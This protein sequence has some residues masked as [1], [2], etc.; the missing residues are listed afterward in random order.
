M[1]R[2]SSL[3]NRENTEQEREHTYFDRS[4]EPDADVVVEQMI[5]FLRGDAEYPAEKIKEN[6]VR[7]VWKITL[8]RHGAFLVKHYRY[9]KRYD[10][11]RYRFV[12][13]KAQKEAENLTELAR[14][15]VPVPR[16]VA[17]KRLDGRE[18]LFVG[19]FLENARPWPADP[20]RALLE[21]L[22]RAVRRLHD[23]KFYHRDLHPGNVLLNDESICLIDFHRGYFLPYL[24]R[25]WEI[26]ML[27]MLM[28]GFCATNDDERVNCFVNA[29][30]GEDAPA[31]QAKVRQAAG[32]LIARQLRSRSRRCV[33]NSTRFAVEKRG[34]FTVFRRRAFSRDFIMSLLEADG[35][36][37]GRNHRGEVA[38][39]THEGVDV[40]R[41]RVRYS[42]VR[43]YA[44]RFFPARLY[45]AWRAGNG[46][47]VR[48]VDVAEPLAYVR[49]IR[50]GSLREE[51][52]ITS[53]LKG[54]LPLGR[55][56][57][58]LYGRGQNAGRAKRNAFLKSLAVFIAKLHGTGFRQ[59]DLAPKNIFVREDRDSW[60]YRLIDLDNVKMRGLN[61]RRILR[62][63]VQ[64]GNTEEVS[65]PW[66]DLAR[67]VRIYAGGRFWDAD[68]VKHVKEALCREQF[69]R[70]VRDQPCSISRFNR[71]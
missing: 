9:M 4:Q 28:K 69:R 33:V 58:G 23:E 3:V 41:K 29:Y 40:C 46:L 21:K 25:R 17:W 10:R 66:L 15:G 24:P 14:R 1:K 8:P 34:A 63:L 19:E 44:A 48:K 18:S 50:F 59:H 20:D 62:N 30:A 67:F 61:R 2:G 35:E 45:A 54:Y 42:T 43:G 5:R 64:L 55:Y 32:R 26:K 13:E 39:I 7:T 49:I 36:I 56:L 37:A 38:L 60:R 22:A 16:V 6:R 71:E 70:I 68:T 65:L 51:F 53:Q 12:A 52:L 31:L 47:L 27:G 11:I 57:A